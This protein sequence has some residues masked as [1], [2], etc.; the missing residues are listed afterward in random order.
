METKYCPVSFQELDENLLS[1]P[2]E[3]TLTPFVYE[4][5]DQAGGSEWLNMYMWAFDRRSRIN[6]CKIT[7]FPVYECIE[8][9][10]TCYYQ[11]IPNGGTIHEAQYILKDQTVYWDEDLAENL[12]ESICQKL[13]GKGK[14]LPLNFNFGMYTDIYFYT[15]KKKPYM[16][17]FFKSLA[18]RANF[19]KFCTS[20]NFYFNRRYEY[21]T[22]TVHES[23]VSTFLRLMTRKDL[24]FNGWLTVTGVEVHEKSPFRVSNKN[25]REFFIDWETMKA[26][27][28]KICSSWRIKIR[29]AGYDFEVYGH[30]GV[31]RFVNAASTKDCIFMIA[32]DSKVLE[33]KESRAKFCLVYGDVRPLDDAQAIRFKSEPEMLVAF[34]RL[35]TYLDPDFIFGYNIYKFDEPYLLGRYDI[36][37]IP[38]ESIPNFGRLLNCKTEVYDQQ[39]KSSGR[40]ESITTFIKAPGRAATYDLLP[41]IKALY[42]LRMYSLEFVSNAFLKSGKGGNS[43]DD[44]VT[45]A[46]MFDAYE[47]YHHAETEEQRQIGIDKMTRI[48]NYCVRDASLTIDLFENRLMWYHL[49]SLS[50]EGGVSISD[51][52]LK[53]EQCRCYS[54]LYAQCAKNNYVLSN[55]K[56]FDYYYSGGFVGKPIPGVY[57]YVF[58]LDFT[59]LYPSIIQA[60]NLCWRTFIPIWKWPDIPKDHCEIINVIQEEPTVHFSLSRKQDIEEKIK[61]KKKNY[62]VDITD[63]E[64]EYIKRSVAV[65]KKNIDQ[66]KVNEDIKESDPDNLW[67]L[68]KDHKTTRHYEFR[69][70]KKRYMEGFLPK[71]EREWVASRKLVKKKIK[72]LNKVLEGIEEQKKNLLK[73]ESYNDEL[74]KRLDDLEKEAEPHGQELEKYETIISEANMKI[75]NL[76]H[77]F[78]DVS[79]IDHEEYLNGQIEEIK[80]AIEYYEIENKIKE[81]NEKLEKMLLKYEDLQ[82]LL[83]VR[84][85][86]ELLNEEIRQ[87]EIKITDLISEIA[88]ADKTQNA[89]KIVAN[90][91]YGFTGVREGMLSGVFIAICVTFLGRKLINRANEVL[92]D[93]FSHMGAKIV[94]NDTDSSMLSLDIKDEDVISGKVNLK[95]LGK[96]MEEIIS[97]REE[98]RDK[99]GNIIKEA[100]E[101]VFKDPLK[102][103]FEDCCQMCP[104]KPKYYLK[105][106]R[107]VDPKKIQEDGFFELEDGVP[108]V[109]KKGVLTAKRGNSKFAMKVYQDLAD[110]VL[111]MKSIT[112]S[113]ESLSGHVK[114]LLMDEYPARE[115][116]KVTELGSDY[117]EESYYMNVF[118]QNLAKWGK[119]VRPGDRIEYLIVKTRHEVETGESQNVGHKCR[120]IEMWLDDENREGID[121]EYYVEKGLQ[122]QYD[123]LF[124]V[125]YSKI[126]SDPKFSRVGYQ[127][128]FGKNGK[129]S[130]SHFVHFS[131]PIK[132]I[133]AMVKDFMNVADPYFKAY[134]EKEFE[135]EYDPSYPRNYYVAE[136]V[137]YEL[138]R[139]TTYIS[140]FLE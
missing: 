92:E 117:V 136:L 22:L 66:E 133:T 53:G 54:Q 12:F 120:E 37:R 2:T 76:K 110:R 113:L 79:D 95:E 94:Y 123:D 69:F 88:S 50:G 10:D 101:P 21:I 90:S 47:S 130:Q 140:R 96:L 125:G 99:N 24:K 27:D 93:K 89:I 46:E 81:L 80:E 34:S 43:S 17:I 91:G 107:N 106:I 74:Q 40:G 16:Y 100:I 38:Q 135:I 9:S 109:K 77:S 4:E 30:K 139:I 84:K 62:D 87:L 127:P 36:H 32:V 31:K 65:S 15:G 134:L 60:Y 14:A 70:I 7:N 61:L 3:L 11:E 138:D 29:L 28:P 33:E 112:S 23:K 8:L 45:V 42:K 104:I 25:V 132:M 126:T 51:I 86:N 97:G 18:D 82:R 44:K 98:V 57:A 58:T 1:E 48:A 118:A 59:S 121:Y 103:E 129:K 35:L 67:D 5:Y 20:Y 78:D 119:P 56:Y 73:P 131:S 6:L 55:S 72:D 64:Y 128:K 85:N 26:V 116:T 122:T 68:P 63:E 102:M 71:L 41:G 49:R 75:D 39:W 108:Y 124:N 115:L 137:V 52:Y 19:R 83:D 111:F 105:A 114:S 13:K